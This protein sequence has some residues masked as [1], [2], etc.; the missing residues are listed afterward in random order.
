M[1]VLGKKHFCIYTDNYNEPRCLDVLAC[2]RGDYIGYNDA[3]I[4][5]FISMCPI[6]PLKPI[7]PVWGYDPVR[8]S[9]AFRNSRGLQFAYQNVY[10]NGT[11]SAFSIYSKLAV[12]PAY[13]GQGADPTPDAE[14]YNFISVRVPEQ[15]ENVNYVKLYAREGN[16]GAWFYIDDINTENVLDNSALS[17]PHQGFQ[18][19]DANG[20]NILPYTY[21][22]YRYYGDRLIS[23][24][25]EDITFKQFDS[26]PKLAESLD[27]CNDRSFFGNY[28]E[29]YDRV[30]VDANI[31]Y[32]ARPRPDD[33]QAVDLKLVP[34]VR[35]LNTIFTADAEDNLFATTEGV[36]NRV[37]GYRLDMSQAPDLFE[38]GS[39]LNISITCNPDQNIHIY[40]AKDSFHSSTF[41]TYPENDGFLSDKLRLSGDDVADSQTIKNYQSRNF[42]PTKQ[43]AGF[44]IAS[45]RT[46]DGLGAVMQVQDCGFDPIAGLD[47]TIQNRPSAVWY[48]PNDRA[49]NTQEPVAY[50]T[51]AS[52]P[53]IISG[54]AL[55]FNCRLFINNSISKSEL[56]VVLGALLSGYELVSSGTPGPG[57]VLSTD[58]SLIDVKNTSSYSIDLGLN[59]YSYFGGQ[60][61]NARKVGLLPLGVKH[62]HPYPRTPLLVAILF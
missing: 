25:P 47:E 33:F 42:N 29:G 28:V 35:P 56:R 53:V 1:K 15:S 8:T 32:V 57:Q 10:N 48:L 37:S 54:S 12:N 31:S 3:E 17:G 30:A 2:L 21:F 46:L 34:E 58:V 41:L 18:S 51:S 26:V 40:Q 49:E 11:V 20:Q 61:P 23:Y 16:D 9:S 24:V 50:G 27:I 55:S 7:V 52:N 45:S 59:S 60:S 5:E 36:R 19:T 44:T 6:T 4:V 39:T 22:A 43:T 38:S 62:L 13:L 14:A